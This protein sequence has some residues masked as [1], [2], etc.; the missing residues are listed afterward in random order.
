[1]QKTLFG[2]LLYVGKTTGFKFDRFAEQDI[3]DIKQY[4]SQNLKRLKNIERN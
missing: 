1:V 3:I 2:I 4:S